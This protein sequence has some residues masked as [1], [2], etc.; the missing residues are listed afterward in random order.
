MPE[1]GEAKYLCASYLAAHQD[2]F[3]AANRVK[4]KR[5]L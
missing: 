2:S 5:G 1:A 3:V 4:L